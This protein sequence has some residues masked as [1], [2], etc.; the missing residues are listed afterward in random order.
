MDLGTFILN[1]SSAKGEPDE[2]RVFNLMFDAA[3]AATPAAYGFS[4]DAIKNWALF[5]SKGICPQCGLPAYSSSLQDSQGISHML[6]V[7]GNDSCL[8]AEFT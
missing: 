5:G 2:E 3:M 4:P 6:F 1:Y 7:C 8:N